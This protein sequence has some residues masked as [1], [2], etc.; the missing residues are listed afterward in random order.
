M[1]STPSLRG[2]ITTTRPNNIRGLGS[3]R[4]G[5]T[6]IIAF[7]TAGGLSSITASKVSCK[8]NSPQLKLV[9]YLNST[10]LLGFS[11]CYPRDAFYMI[12]K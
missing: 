12:L 11:R 1:R 8:V 6:T 3:R 4:L 7:S 9:G 2:V 10:S 5:M